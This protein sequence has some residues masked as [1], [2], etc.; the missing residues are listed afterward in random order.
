MDTLNFDVLA[1]SIESAGSVLALK[2]AMELMSRHW[3]FIFSYRLAIG[4]SHE[5]CK[6]KFLVFSHKSVCSIHKS[7]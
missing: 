4:Y 5:F 3:C 7:V 6:P 2:I 1:D